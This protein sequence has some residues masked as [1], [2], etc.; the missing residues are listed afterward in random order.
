MTHYPVVALAVTALLGLAAGELLGYLPVATCG[1][2]LALGLLWR[3][4]DTR[5]H[6][7]YALLLLCV[8]YGHA[9]YFGVAADDIGHYAGHRVRLTATVAELP[10][11]ERGRTR[12]LARAER[13]EA[14]GRSVPVSGTV[15]LVRYGDG[16]GPFAYGDRI[17]AD[18]TLR[19]VTS[20]RNP[21]GF[22]YAA[23]LWRQGVRTRATVSRRTPV[24]V[25]RA[26]PGPLTWLHG[27]RARM[28]D[29]AEAALP[30]TQAALLVALAAGDARGVPQAVRDRFQAAGVAH[31]LAV[32][33]THLGL[34]AAA[35][36]LLVRLGARLLPA[37]ALLRLTR[38]A[39]LRQVAAGAALV[40]VTAY[41]LLAGA[42]TPT[43]RALVMVVFV[44]VAL[45]S[46]RR[47]HAPTA[48]AAAA[49]GILAWDPRAIGEAS[50]QLSF[51][52]VLAITLVVARLTPP[53]GPDG[54]PAPRLK[55]LRHAALSAAAVTLAAGLA[56]APL[57]AW[58]FGYVSWVGFLANLVL[59]PLTGVVVL[60]LTVFAAVVAPALGFLPL[61]GVVS[62]VLGG[63]LAVVG[64]FAELPG[65]GSGVAPPP[66]ALLIATYGA[67]LAVLLGWRHVGRRSLA[68]GGTA[69][70]LAWALCLHPPP[71]TGLLRVAVLDVGQGD[72]AVAVGPDGAALVI[73]GGTRVRRFDTG[74]LAV[75]PYLRQAGA[76]E[77]SLLATHPQ[78]D[79]E[80]GLIHLVD[81]FHPRAV[82]TNGLRRADRD[83]DND[84]HAALTRAGM[85]PVP[86]AAGTPFDPLPGAT[87]AV[88]NPRAAPVAVA[89]ARA[90]NDTSL[91]VALGLGRHRFLFAADAEG[92]AEAALAASGADLSATV[93]KVP[94]HGSATSSTAPF[95]ARVR[96]S[97]AVIS[98]GRFNPYGHP[99]PAVEHAYRAAGAALFET[100]RDGAVLFETDGR[101]LRMARWTDLAPA[102]VPPWAAAPLA[103]E[104]GNLTRLWRPERLWRTVRTGAVPDRVRPAS[105]VQYAAPGPA[106]GGGVAISDPPSGAVR[107]ARKPLTPLEAEP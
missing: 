4:G 35:V 102:R 11:T 98:A 27:W 49:L 56:T 81:A 57:A 62:H 95:L 66:V 65:A 60:P 32:S 97:V 34:V 8:L 28:R 10:R 46:G 44:V 75:A 9:R 83:F 76:R 24:T 85:A 88:L 64:G 69:F 103:A 104:L 101:T 22:D 12:M 29:A 94:H 71:P 100:A 5:S 20:L 26:G 33:G 73:D 42:R 87:A 47:S 77:V 3:P 39:T 17:T 91:V 78:L 92:P 52:A 89:D 90:L 14:A 63:L 7:L 6:A 70:G 96:P 74:R 15:D 38:R 21:G 59:V 13:I 86:L 67:G 106:T 16:G 55:R 68:L 18:V 61:A 54:G 93:L 19:P 72:A 40:A 37:G 107:D 58:H 79:H 43:L 82:Y 84:F 1:L 30:G 105:L 53:L 99:S 50:F 80:G 23:Y 48:L 2:L 51:V 31:L 45:A 36:F 25:A 41:A